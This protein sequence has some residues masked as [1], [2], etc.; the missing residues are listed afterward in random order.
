MDTRHAVAYALILGLIVAPMLIIWV[1]KRRARSDRR[2]ARRPIRLT[3]EE[4]SDD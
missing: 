2:E 1:L 4:A 3:G